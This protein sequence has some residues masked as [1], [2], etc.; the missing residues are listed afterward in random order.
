MIKKWFALVLTALFSTGAFADYTRY[1]FTG[2]LDGYFV[3]RDDNKAIAH[4]SFNMTTLMTEHF[5]PEEYSGPPTTRLWSHQFYP[6]FGD[7]AKLLTGATTYFEHDGPTNF[8][9]HD[10][11]GGDQITD[12][13]IK[14]LRLSSGGFAYTVD[15]SRWAYLSGG[16]AEGAGTFS[17]FAMEAP[18][19]AGLIEDLNYDGGYYAGMPRIIP[20]FIGQPR[21]VPEPASLTLMAIG[22]LSAAGISRRR[23]RANPAP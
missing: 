7:G 15:Y 21:Q 20:Q 8:D 12:F 13:S 6:F 5:D 2:L 10:D 18:M 17:G 22:V 1:E 19:P 9:I 14:F 4:F 3:Q 23:R 11:Y 16:Y